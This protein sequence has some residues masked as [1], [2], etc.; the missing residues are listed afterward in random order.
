MINFGNSSIRPPYQ[1]NPPL[2]G[3][4]TFPPKGGGK[5]FHARRGGL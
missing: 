3:K 4:E 2:S 1:M 5:M